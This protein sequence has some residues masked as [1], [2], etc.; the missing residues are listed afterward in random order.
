MAAAVS[1]DFSSGAGA[2]S[3]SY[4]PFTK[5]GPAEPAACREPAQ[6]PAPTPAHVAAI[7]KEVIALVGKSFEGIGQCGHGLLLLMLMPG[8]ERVAHTV[9]V[10]F[11][12]SV[13]IMVGLTA[14]NGRPGRSPV[15]GDLPKGAPSLLS[16]GQSQSAGIAAGTARCDGGLGSALPPGHYEAVGE[17]SGP[18]V[19]GVGDVP[20]Y[21]TSIEPVQILPNHT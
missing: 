9:R 13:Q 10:K 17:V 1:A 3:T 19:T 4:P 5:S 21:F 12:S 15:C 11:G 2:S 20:V 8:S 18:G 14:W 7:E 16:P 6:S